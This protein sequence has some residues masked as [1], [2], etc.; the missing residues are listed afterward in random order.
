M[1]INPAICG[2]FVRLDDEGGAF[3]TIRGAT[4]DV[5]ITVLGDGRFRVQSPEPVQEVEGH[6]AAVELAHRLARDA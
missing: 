6:D 3:A 2:V 4:G 5:K 1:R